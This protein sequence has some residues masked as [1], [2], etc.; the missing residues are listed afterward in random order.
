MPTN[1]ANRRL[2]QHHFYLLITIVLL[3]SAWLR[4]FGLG[5]IPPELTHDEAINGLDALSIV[6]GEPP[7]I[8]YVDNN[9]RE[10]LQIY[11]LAVAMWQLGTDPVVLRLVSIFVSLIGV[12]LTVPLARSLAARNW[13]KKQRQLFIIFASALLGFSFY[14]LLFSRYVLR[15]IIMLPCQIFALYWF[16]RGWRQ[17][18]TQYYFLSGIGVGLSLYTYLPAR[19][20]PFVMVFWVAREIAKQRQQWRKGFLALTITFTTALLIFLP[21]GVYFIHHPDLFFLRVSQVASTGVERRGEQ[22]ILFTFF[23]SVWQHI[24]MFTLRGEQNP[25]YNLPGRT[26]LNPLMSLG[27][28]P[29][30]LFV[31]KSTERQL[32]LIWLVVMLL[33]S[34]LADGIASMIRAIGALPAIVLATAFG[35]FDLFDWLRGRFD[36]RPNIAY[37][38]TPLL[39]IIFFATTRDYFFALPRSQDFMTIVGRRVSYLS[40]IKFRQLDETQLLFSSDLSL[41][42]TYYALERNYPVK[43]AQEHIQRTD[44]LQ[45]QPIALLSAVSECRIT[46]N[47][48]WFEQVAGDGVH[49]GVLH[50][51][52]LTRNNISLTAPIEWIE[53]DNSVIVAKQIDLVRETPSDTG[54]YEV[55]GVMFSDEICLLLYQSPIRV[56]QGLVSFALTWEAVLPKQATYMVETTLVSADLQ[57]IAPPLLTELALSDSAELLTQQQISYPIPPE[58][59]AGKYLFQIKLLKDGEFVPTHNEHGR[60]IGESA[61]AG[62][63][64]QPLEEAISQPEKPF[65]Q[66]GTENEIELLTATPTIENRQLQLQLR[67]L[68][69][70]K[71]FANYIVFIHILDADGNLV[72]QRDA[73]PLDGRMPTLMWLPNE[74]ITDLHTLDLSH[75]PAGNYHIELGLYT[76]MTGERLTVNNGN[77]PDR[78][79][80]SSFEI[81]P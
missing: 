53:D 12:A 62:N 54:V 40:E 67:W 23:Q 71:P 6:N 68:A 29:F 48:L 78:V 52:D 59:A 30:F 1:A 19:L 9:G 47:M 76:L 27:L 65:A 5:E 14:H 51:S 35:W 61:F 57:P 72:A 70:L 20:F 4:L 15:A 7:Q 18:R 43:N 8:F 81:T 56:A 73:P 75:L 80:I 69:H 55:V 21:L 50:P 79:R 25:L 45:S 77:L 74:Q 34:L 63:L 26:A 64:T 58:L 13:D 38:T 60:E 39:A 10:P 24:E 42:S 44:L 36:F 3:L 46:P 49:V 2:S 31:Q 16:Q 66:W 22:G 11:L 37:I 32:L 33:P 28:I 17:E 41:P